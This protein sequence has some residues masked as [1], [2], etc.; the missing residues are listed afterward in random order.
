MVIEISACWVDLSD[1]E[2]G[3]GRV[4]QHHG[5]ADRYVEGPATIV[6]GSLFAVTAPASTSA[7][8]K[9][10]L[11]CAVAAPVAPGAV[12]HTRSSAEPRLRALG[13]L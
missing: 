11:Q 2:C 3:T 10:T 7:T 12:K 5:S 13:E 9:R 6:P 4:G 8:Q 1:R